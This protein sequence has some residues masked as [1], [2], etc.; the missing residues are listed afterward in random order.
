MSSI[1]I[2]PGIDLDEAELQW[3]FVR[4]SGPG[5]Q[6]VNKV[7]TAVQLRWDV[8]ATSVLNDEIKARLHKLAGSRM[9]ADG[10]LLIESRSTRSQIRNRELALG[11]LITL[12]RQATVRPKTRRATKPTASSQATRV[13]RKVRRG[14]TKALRRPVR[15]DDE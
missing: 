14:Q 4:A 15:R 1:H 10:V 13:A 9:T 11:E 12:V 8:G 3:D 6:N 5:G 2:A 7:A